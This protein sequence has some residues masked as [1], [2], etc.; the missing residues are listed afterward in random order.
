[1]S[2]ENGPLIIADRVCKLYPLKSQ[3]RRVR[4]ENM[5]SFLEKGFKARRTGPQVQA[6]QDVC[7]E[8]QRGEAVG[9]VGRNGSGKTT[10]L[11]ILAGITRPSSGSAEIRGRFSELFSLNAGFNMNLSGR[12]NIYLHAA[13]KGIPRAEIEAL[14]EDIIAFS[15]L[16]HYIDA[17]VK[18]Y[19]SGMRSRLGFSIIVH[20][21]PDI[22]LID[23]A[24]SAGD[25]RFQKKCEQRL[26][27]LFTSRENTLL[28]VSHGLGS[29][30]KICRRVIWLEDGRV[31]QDGPVEEVLAAY[32]DFLNQV[33]GESLPGG[34]VDG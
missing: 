13:I 7:F 6:L 10:L 24:L 34:V 31:E 2:S 1:M 16:A 23:E 14:M 21:L 33:P 3:L 32:Q 22:I 5:A 19:S 18:H 26:D 9:I 15:E 27:E 30:E 12:K 20:T 8:I 29:I 25:G 11:K 17:P 4:G 28:F